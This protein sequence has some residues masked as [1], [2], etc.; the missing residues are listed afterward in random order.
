M[1]RVGKMDEET[2]GQCKAHRSQLVDPKTYVQVEATPV[3][4]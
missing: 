3:A 2:Q 4:W 1:E